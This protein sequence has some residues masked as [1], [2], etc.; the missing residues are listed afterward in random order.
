MI[1]VVIADDGL[2]FKVHSHDQETGEIVEVT[3]QYQIHP[4]AIEV[5][6]QEVAGFHIGQ[7][8]AK[9]VV[10]NVDGDSEDDG[11]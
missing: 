3:H 7:V 2:H 8:L 11:A 6:G 10:V 1:A 4:M 5:D 9:H